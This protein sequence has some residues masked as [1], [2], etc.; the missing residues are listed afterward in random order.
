MKFKIVIALLFFVTATFAAMH[1]VEHITHDDA[2]VCLVC[3]VNDTFE[4]ADLV[5]HNYNFEFVCCKEKQLTS[6]IA[7]VTTH[8]LQYPARA[9]PFIA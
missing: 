7:R 3:T 2:D 9:P 6:Q 8:K 5:E 4:A 1:E